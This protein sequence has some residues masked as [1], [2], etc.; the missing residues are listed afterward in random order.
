MGYWLLLPIVAKGEAA[1]QVSVITWG[2]LEQ[3]LFQFEASQSGMQISNKLQENLK[4][5]RRYRAEIFL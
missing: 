5:D 2:D 4:A 1:H 3:F